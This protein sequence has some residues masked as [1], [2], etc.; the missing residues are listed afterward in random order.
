MMHE[1]TMCQETFIST[2]TTY[3]EIIFAYG[4][5]T[6]NMQLNYRMTKLNNVSPNMI[7]K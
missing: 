6:N 1:R 2:S 4:V 3:F 5:Q 7:I